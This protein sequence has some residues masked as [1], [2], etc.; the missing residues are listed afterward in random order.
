MTRGKPRLDSLQILRALA[1]LLVVHF[2]SIVLAENLGTPPRQAAFFSLENFGAVG[3]DVFFVLSGF[4][5]SLSAAR[6]HGAGDFL[7]RRA[8]RLM[9]LYVLLTLASVATRLI[10]GVRVDPSYVAQ[11]LLFLPTFTGTALPVIWVG[12]TLAFEVFFYV[13]VGA[14]L[15]LPARR[16]LAVRA[17]VVVAGFILAG[18][19]AHAVVGG[20]SP[21]LPGLNVVA[22][23]IALEFV[24]GCLIGVAWQRWR[25]HGPALLASGAGLLAL[26]VC[27][28]FGQIFEAK[29]VLDGSLS[30]HRLVIW[31]IPAAVL[32][33][34]ATQL[35]TEMGS[36]VG[37][38]LVGLGDRSYSIYLSSAIT[39][40][41]VGAY[42]PKLARAGGDAAVLLAVAIST[43][44]GVGCFR[45]VERPVTVALNRWYARRAPSRGSGGRGVG[46]WLPSESHP[47][48]QLLPEP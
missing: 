14:L 25:W 23:P 41:I 46:A 29:F 16:A 27:V 24:F 45:Y 39:L 38:I 31:G 47:V 33:A 19:A 13:V 22:N 1:A 26:T 9:P 48:P 5:V 10:R 8:I 4:V 40:P 36:R 44:V 37:R 20:G 30:W 18:A 6:A 3:V 17:A 28:G 43:V 11:S 15:S 42:W 32:V 34:G 35:R 2:H 7:L 21:L 12:W